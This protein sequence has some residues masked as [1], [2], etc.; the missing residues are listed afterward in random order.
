MAEPLI[1]S[2]FGIVLYGEHI[3]ATP[4]DLLGELLGAAAVVSGIAIWVAHRW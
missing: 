1:G 2:T 3:R 4:V